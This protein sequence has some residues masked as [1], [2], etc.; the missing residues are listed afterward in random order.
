VRHRNVL[1]LLDLSGHFSLFKD[2]CHNAHCLVHPSVLTFELLPPEMQIHD[3]LVC[4]LVHE[5]ILGNF[6]KCPVFRIC[7]FV[8]GLLELFFFHQLPVES[9]LKLSLLLV[10]NLLDCSISAYH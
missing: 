4:V 8:L 1:I 2:L 3:Q 5:Q 10:K 9:H 6:L 7:V